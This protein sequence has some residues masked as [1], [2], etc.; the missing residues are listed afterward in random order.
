MNYKF[1][2]FNCLLLFTTNTFAQTT[3]I[4][5]TTY[6][7]D[8][9][10]NAENF[11][12]GLENKYKENY[13]AA[14]SC[15]E[16]ALNFNKDDDAS[17][18]ELS[19]LYRLKNR[20]VEALNMIEKAAKL[21][22]ENKW[23]QIRLAQFCQQN[24]DYERFIK[25]YDKLMTDDPTNLDY[26]ETY[27]DVLLQIGEYEKIIEKINVLES[28]MGKNELVTLQKIEIYKSIGDNK[29][30]MEEMENL[31]EVAP[32]NTRYLAMLAQI[33]RQNK[34][35]VEAYKLYLRIKELDPNDKYIN[36]SL[37]DYYQSKGELDKAFDEFVAAIKNKNLDYDTKVQIYELWSEQNEKSN[38]SLTIQKAEI[39]G[40][41]FIETHP[42]KNIGYY[43][44]GVVHFNNNDYKIAQNYFI[45]SIN[46]EKSNFATLYHLC[47]VDLELN[48]YEMAIK[49]TEDAISYFPEQPIFYLFAGLS[50]Y[51]FKDYEK[52]IKNLEKG[53]KLSANKELTR[54]FDMYLGDTYNIMNDHKKSFEAYERVLR[55]DPENIYVLNNYAYNLAVDNQELERALQ[56]SAKTIEKEPKNPTYLDTYAWIFYKMERF[57]EAK[58]WMEKTFKYEKNPNGVNY[59]HYGDILFKLGD[60]KGALQNWKKAKKAGGASKFIDDKIKDEK[61]YE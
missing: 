33:Y 47:L 24:S 57:A 51:N 53:R 29:K 3:A 39:V 58:K 9:P 50:Y 15:F 11:S 59:E 28:M 45:E 46:R 18:Y 49:H 55:A 52:T 54:D 42:D 44:L 56:M 2:I 16:Q 40:Q 14:I 60:T 27:I 37:Y 10:K 1:L 61:M 31:V 23:Y 38:N 7:L 12:K 22:P 20:D 17:M 21:Q 30:I 8:L 34:N 43:I 6:I 25:I 4:A 26:L 41:A 48:D 32:T 36:V 35:D 5:D 19:D 13:D